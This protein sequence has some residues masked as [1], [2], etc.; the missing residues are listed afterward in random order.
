MNGQA[1][2]PSTVITLKVTKTLVAGD[3]VIEAPERTSRWRFGEAV[4]RH[5]VVRVVDEV[6][7]LYSRY[8]ERGSCNDGRLFNGF[9][10]TM[11]LAWIPGTSPGLIVS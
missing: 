8:V 7:A 4:C 1:S 6:D 2:F 10:V 9:I 5:F 11:Y 3:Q